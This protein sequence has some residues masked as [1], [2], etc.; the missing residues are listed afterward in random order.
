LYPRY[1]RSE[2]EFGKKIA[3]EMELDPFLDEYKHLTGVELRVVGK[4]E[5]PDFVCMQGS[6]EVGLELVKAMRNPVTRDWERILG[7][8]GEDDPLDAAIRVQEAVYT[9]ET[10]RVKPD[11]SHPDATI[12]VVQ[13]IGADGDEVVNYLDDDLMDEMSD[14]GFS[15]IWVADY[16]PMETH[17]T[18]QLIGIKPEKWRGSHSHRFVDIKPYG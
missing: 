11:W 16:W 5:R 1:M 7:S 15:E 13:L 17:G 4:T 2:R 6:H 10:K 9:K 18:V 8:D 14:T 3:E 12:L